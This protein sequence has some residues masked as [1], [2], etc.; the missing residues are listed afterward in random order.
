MRKEAPF[1]PRKALLLANL[2]KKES[3][4]LVLTEKGVQ[5]AERIVRFHRLFELYLA[6]VLKTPHEKVH[7][8]A[9][10]ME[11]SLTDSL[12]EKLTEFLNHPEK[13]P[14]DQWIPKGKP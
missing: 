11:H 2:L 8:E 13:D 5:E 7:T 10:E 14:H 1:L 4:R 6:D 3:G 12:E 9:E